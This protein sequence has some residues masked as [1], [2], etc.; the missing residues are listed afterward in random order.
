MTNDQFPVPLAGGADDQIISKNMELKEYILII[1]KHLR[2]FLFVIFL[3]LVSGLTYFYARPT[4][5]D[6]SLALNITRKGIEQTTDYKYDY[7]Y[8][9]NAD[10]KFADTVV[11]WLRDPGTVRGIYENSGIAAV[12]LSLK[13]LT[14]LFKP[15][16]RSSEL[17]LVYFSSSNEKEIKNI[18]DSIKKEISQN[19]NNLNYLQKDANWFDIFGEDPVI[20]KH[21]FNLPLIVAGLFF[22]GIFLAFW[23]VLITHYFI[24]DSE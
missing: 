15:E 22:F 23:V 8:R 21:S 3:V 9:L 24:K 13:K 7:Y 18:S 4:S 17:V 2:T 16:K 11:E 12:D 10:E 20:V 14:K 5:Y 19:T 6:A 1:K